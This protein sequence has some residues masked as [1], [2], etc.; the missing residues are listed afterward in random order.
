MAVVHVLAKDFFEYNLVVGC[1]IYMCTLLVVEM[2]D[3]Q[4]WAETTRKVSELGMSRYN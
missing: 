3:G 1:H 2:V 4:C